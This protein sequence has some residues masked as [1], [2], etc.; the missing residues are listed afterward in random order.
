[1]KMKLGKFLTSR[2][3]FLTQNITQIIAKLQQV[4]QSDRRT[5]HYEVFIFSWGGGEIDIDF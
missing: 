3:T 2:E 5:K 4:P 1:M